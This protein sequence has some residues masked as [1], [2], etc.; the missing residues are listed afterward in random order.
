MYN[1][2]YIKTDQ[3]QTE[4]FEYHLEKNKLRDEDIGN[5]TAYGIS[6]N[7]TSIHIK[8]ISCNKKAVIKIVNLLNMYQASPIHLYDI[9][10]D[11]IA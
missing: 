11:M 1:E 4:I 6:L 5:Y 7:H 10:C 8:D 2:N 3:E 9:V